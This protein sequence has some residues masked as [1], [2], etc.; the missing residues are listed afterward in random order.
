MERE[1]Q[2][3]EE[4]IVGAE[5]RNAQA[6]DAEDDEEEEDGTV[7]LSS[8]WFS[9]TSSLDSS[10]VESALDGKLKVEEG[11]EVIRLGRIIGFGRVPLMG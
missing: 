7:K 3:L 10:E 5:E 11:G 6:D 2:P 8:P 1:E 9:S 4:D